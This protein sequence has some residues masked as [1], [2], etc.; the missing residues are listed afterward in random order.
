MRRI[1]VLSR[2]RFLTA[3]GSV[4]V[5][6]MA[7]A[8][9]AWGQLL[10]NACLTDLPDDL[11]AHP[12]IVSAWE[13][14]D[15]ARVWDVHVHLA[16]IGDS[17]SGIVVSAEMQSLRH[18]LQ[19][20]QRLFYMNG[21]CASEVPGEVDKSYVARLLNL[22]NGLPAGAKLLLFAFDRPYNQKGE[23]LAAESTLYVPNE[24][25]MRIARSAPS[26]FEWACSIHPYRTD[27]VEALQSAV[28]DGARAVKWLP[29][30]M[31]IDP[32]SP[33][34]DRFYAA[35]AALNIPLITH[36]GEEKAVHG[37]G[38]PEWGNPLRLRRAMD[39]GVRVVMAHCGTIGTN[40]DIDKGPSGPEVPTFDLFARLM[41]DPRYV[42]HLHGDISAIVLVNRSPEVIRTLI[43]R[44]E[45][46]SRLL[47]G[48]D[49][50]LPGILPLV[51]LSRLVKERLLEADAVPVLDRLRN[52]NPILFDFVLKRHLQSRD[53]RFSPIVFESQRFFERDSARSGA[54]QERV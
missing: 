21:G 14:I 37:P 38:L 12:L 34:C 44:L 15:P 46:H 36:T 39:S 18:P 23:A 8:G 4:A 47:F 53:R 11:A 24:Y 45:W 48:T 7:G 49:Y 35:M 50:P 27:C 5:G 40:T 28:R 6:T 29:P 42:S 51:N 52:H 19:Y 54:D 33:L 25:A 26:R 3:A 41:D 2:R 30:T 13:G 16:G 32:G 43:E 10:M 20:L 31:G 17:D 9:N 1:S 22:A